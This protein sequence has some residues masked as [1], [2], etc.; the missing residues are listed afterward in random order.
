MVARVLRVV[1]K[2]LLYSC[3]GQWLLG[4]CYLVSSALR[5]VAMVFLCNC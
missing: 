5:A 4:R 3:Y 1:A 2:K